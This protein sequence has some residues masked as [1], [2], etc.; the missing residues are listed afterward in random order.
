MSR[1]D[2]DPLSLMAGLVLALLAGLF[3]LV[4]TT[5]VSVSARWVA[6]V[7][8]LVVGGVGLAATLRTRP[9]EDGGA[10]EPDE[11]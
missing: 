4:D 3:L 10:L 1:H 9:D 5:A 11:S 6:P 2:R 7:L 8:L